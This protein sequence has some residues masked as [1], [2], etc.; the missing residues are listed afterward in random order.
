M[1]LNDLRN[2]FKTEIAAI[3]DD[4]ANSLPLSK[5]QLRSA[6]TDNQIEEVHKLIKEINEATDKN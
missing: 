2:E 4:L 5:P 1:G 3:A 6:F